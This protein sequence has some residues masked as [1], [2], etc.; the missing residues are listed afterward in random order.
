[1]MN[2]KTYRFYLEVRPEDDRERWQE[3]ADAK[4][5]VSVSIL[6]DN[7]FAQIVSE[8]SARIWANTPVS[9]ANQIISGF[10]EDD[11]G[12]FFSTVMSAEDANRVLSEIHEYTKERGYWTRSCLT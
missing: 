11:K 10:T 7:L 8:A 3:V 12:Y 6:A 2:P 4:L 1:M 5:T 9:L